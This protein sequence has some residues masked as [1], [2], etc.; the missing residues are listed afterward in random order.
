M[1]QTTPSTLRHS[2]PPERNRGYRPAWWLPGPHLPTLWAARA[3]PVPRV[4]VRIE[5]LEL[6][7][8]DFLDLAFTPEASESQAPLVVILHGLEGSMDSPYARRLMHA[9][10]A[11]GWTACV[12]H[13][14]GCSGVPNR[15]PRSY[16]SGDTGDIAFVLDTLSARQPKRPLT[17]A[18]FSM[19]GN[20]L[21][22]YLG[23]RGVATPL[24][25]AVA[26]SV[27][28]DLAAAAERLAQ[29]F[30]RVYQSHLIGH[31][32][33]RMRAKL[34]IHPHLPFSA[35]EL[36][37]V[38]SFREYDDWVTA[39]LHGFAGAD[40]Y[41]ATS[42]SA[43]FVG[44]VKQPTLVLHARDDP[45]LPASAV[46]QARDCGPGITLELPAH[47]GHIGFVTDPFPGLVRPWLEER[48]CAFLENALPPAAPRHGGLHG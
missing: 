23:E 29:G 16:H 39:P 26:V 41:Y 17:A 8:G 18:G 9:V 47:G 37:R 3:R 33:A 15:L 40:E 44:A 4:P 22:K 46:P 1:A 12:M 27:P 2:T 20:V 32:K 36:A 10:A 31:L 24:S 28:F 19:G 5:R 48:L 13:F 43:R 35:R 30:S 11:R 38:R 7:D 45:F 6:P 34:R 14:R 42:S 21:L 25:A